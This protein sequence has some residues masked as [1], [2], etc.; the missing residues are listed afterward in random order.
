MDNIDSCCVCYNETLEK[1]LCNHPICLKC[2]SNCQ[3]CPLC[4]SNFEGNYFK[5]RTE[6]INNA[7]PA[8]AR[9]YFIKIRGKNS[10]TIRAD[11]P[12]FFIYHYEHTYNRDIKKE[13]LKNLVDN[14][15]F[16]KKSQKFYYGGKY[17]HDFI[18]TFINIYKYKDKYKNWI[19]LN[20]PFK[21]EIILYEEQLNIEINN[22]AVF[23]INNLEIDNLRKLIIKFLRL[24]I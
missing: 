20:F 4:R 7:L 17:T 16:Y 3:T 2:F 5:P 6:I 11:A 15:N 12:D 1:T 22:E 8:Y 23:Y 18:L 19:S 21:E 9:P 10:Y 14:F 13:H 24:D